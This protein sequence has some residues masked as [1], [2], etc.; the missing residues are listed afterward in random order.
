M[1][2]ISLAHRGL[3]VSYAAIRLWCLTVG[4][5][6]ALRLTRRQGRL[7]D[8]GPLDEDITLQGQRRSLW[9]AVDQA[10]DVLSIAASSRVATVGRRHACSARC[11][12]GRRVR[13]GGWSPTR[14]ESASPYGAGPRPTR[15]RTDG[16]CP[17]RA[18]LLRGGA[19]HEAEGRRDAR[20][21]GT[22]RV[23]PPTGWCPLR[24]L[25]QI[26]DQLVAGLKQFLLIDDVVAVEDGAALVS[27]Q[28]HG[29]PF[30]NIRADQVAGGG[31][32]P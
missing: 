6:D 13:R 16:R 21:G 22:N 4:S 5:V 11:C 2:K 26:G 9:R 19:S 28:E 32:A 14:S 25:R 18:A 29:D 23:G 24:L 8:I 15:G 12:R 20:G 7:D 31:A 17:A 1:S 3:T 10:G 27:G 30:G